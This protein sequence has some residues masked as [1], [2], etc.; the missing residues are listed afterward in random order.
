MGRTFFSEAIS[1]VCDK[2]YGGSTN[3]MAT[4]LGINQACI[5]KYTRGQ[6]IPPKEMLDRL[7]VP[8]GK[9]NRR[10]LIKAYLADHMPP[11]TAGLIKLS[12]TDNRNVVKLDLPRPI[13]WYVERALLRL[14]N[15]AI[16]SRECRKMILAID[17]MMF[18]L[19]KHDIMGKKPNG[20]SKL[21]L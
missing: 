18:G 1:K 8:M 4:H 19:N 2:K 10:A 12:D 16:H 13:P 15:I 21:R 5:H 6:S 7:L 9:I 17:K 3:K 14:A 20:S 11:C